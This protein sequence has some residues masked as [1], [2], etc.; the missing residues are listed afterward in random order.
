M[1]LLLYNK[2]IPI[3]EVIK[4][5]KDYKTWKQDKIRSEVYEALA[6]IMFENEGTKEDM[7]KALKWFNDKFYE[8]EE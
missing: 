7:D 2:I 5:A 1:P 8:Y 4:M 3:E 6:N